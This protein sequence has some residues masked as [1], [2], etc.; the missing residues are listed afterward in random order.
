MATG[1]SAAQP[2]ISARTTPARPTSCPTRPSTSSWL[3]ITSSGISRATVYLG[4]DDSRQANKLSYEALNFKLAANYEL[5]DHLLTAGFEQDDLDVYNLFIQ[6]VRT[7]NRFDESDECSA[8]NPNGCIDSF[9]EGR[10]DD[11]YY[12]NAAPSNDPQEGAAVWGYKI[13]TAYLQDEWITAGGDLR[14]WT[15]RAWCSRVSASTGP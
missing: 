11:I 5:G 7:E 9:R 4:T 10:P 2:S 12:G 8:S 6:H 1:G 3:P 15:A 13:N 14:P